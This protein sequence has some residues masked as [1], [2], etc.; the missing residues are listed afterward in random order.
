M[1]ELTLMADLMRKIEAVAHKHGASKIAGVRVRLGALAPISP[2]HFREHFEWAARGTL[3][4][5]ARVEIEALSDL[6]DPHAQDLWLVSVD[7]ET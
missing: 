1:H 4:E 5:G 2:E 3:A 6:S 7:V